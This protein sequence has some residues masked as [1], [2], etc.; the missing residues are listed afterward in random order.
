ME[1]TLQFDPANLCVWYRP[2]G[3]EES[4]LIDEVARTA[5]MGEHKVAVDRVRT[6]GEDA[7]RTR[8]AHMLSAVVHEQRH[9]VDVLLTNY[10]QSLIRQFTSLLINV[11]TALQAVTP[12]GR[13]GVPITVYGDDVKRSVLGLRKVDLLSRVAEDVRSRAKM[14]K[15]ELHEHVTQDHGSISVGGTAQVEALAFQTQVAML[16]SE[17]GMEMSIAVQQDMPNRTVVRN[18]Y[19]WAALMGHAL[20]LGKPDNAPEQ[21]IRTLGPPTGAL[22]YGTL[23]TR[24]WGQK[25]SEVDGG[26][27]GAAAARF[28]PLF[29]KLRSTRALA[30]ATSTREAW[31]AV[32]DACG[33]VFGRSAREELQHDLDHNVSYCDQVADILGDEDNAVVQFLRGV[34][35]ARLRLVALLDDSPET[36]LDPNCYAAFLREID[37]VPIFVSPGG[38]SEQVPDG[39]SNLWSGASRLG[40]LGRQMWSWAKAPAG[41]V[42]TSDRIHIVADIESWKCV[43]KDLMPITKL[44]LRGRRQAPVLG[45]ELDHAEV[46]LREMGI[47][48]RFDPLFAAPIVDSSCDAFWYW[49][50]RESAICDGCDCQVLRG[51]GHYIPAAL[52]R[53]NDRIATWVVEKLGGGDLG[54]L[55]VRKDWSGWVVCDNCYAQI[56]ELTTAP[57]G[58]QAGSS[59]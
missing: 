39:W 24:L 49:T 51:S 6:I 44:L 11:P 21:V 5:L 59:I 52:F 26:H 15:G 8:C 30:R 1:P 19:G 16:Q 55:W 40:N 37:P 29:V 41:L 25:Q 34:H 4:S 33:E 12:E 18:Q 53:K 22:L 10:G 31:Q 56:Q 9:F 46:I 54:L 48:P 23:M 13:V 58:S 45:P 50:R 36:V 27:S 7:L 17:F 57:P 43:V 20:G 14:M 35:A 38:T 2:L 47:E 28:D 42:S 3:E 32:D